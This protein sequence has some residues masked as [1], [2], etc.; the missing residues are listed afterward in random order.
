MSDEAVSIYIDLKSPYSY[1]A[2]HKALALE[3]A[4]KVIFDWRPFVLNTAERAKADRESFIR[5]ARY[6]YR[7]VRRFATPLNLTVKGPKQIHDSTLASIALLF[8][9][10]AGAHRRYI[11]ECYRRFFDR[12][13]ELD[14]AKAIEAL[15]ADCGIDASEFT[16]YA[17]GEGS[18]LLASCRAEADAIGVFAVPTFVIGTELYWGQDRMDMALTEAGIV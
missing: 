10:N 16:P 9:Q 17:A 2:A 14:N 12:D 8:S 4:G 18:D 7:D 5:R 15:L 11:S 13:L 1:V 3:E 6:I